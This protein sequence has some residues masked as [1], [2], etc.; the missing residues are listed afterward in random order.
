MSQ[1]AGESY[2]YPKLWCPVRRRVV[3][4]HRLVAEQ[5]VG[6]FLP[7]SV[8]VHHVNEDENDFR[9][10]NLV[11]C[12]DRAYHK[13]L[14]VRQRALRACGHVDWRRCIYCGKHDAVENLKRYGRRML[15][16]KCKNAYDK[17][18]RNRGKAK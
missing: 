13:L 1:R 16:S 3:K 11:I 17:E 2:E 9:N 10:S 6:H 14:H 12:Q 5:V 15:H 4:R 8:E 18:Y 7:S